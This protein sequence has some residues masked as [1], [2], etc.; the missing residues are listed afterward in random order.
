MATENPAPEA[1]PQK[2]GPLVIILVVV[3][4]LV[5]AG[6]AFGIWKVSSD[7]SSDAGP[8]AGQTAKGLY[9]AWQDGDQAAAAKDATP[10]AV[11][12]IFKV[13]T[14]DASGLEFGGCSATGSEPFPKEC[15]WSRPG[16]E[17][18]MT[19]EKQDDKPVVT[20]VE[21]GPA[22]LPPDTDATG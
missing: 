20:N 5:V 3:G 7:D 4:V 6:I 10:V 21:Y 2:R 9:N 17:L 8:P 18:T 13:D 1:A 11:T 15:V 12:A 19:V 16:G 22:G 14:S